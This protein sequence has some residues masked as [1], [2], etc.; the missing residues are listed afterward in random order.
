MKRGGVCWLFAAIEGC[1]RHESACSEDC[2][3]AWIPGATGS[4]VCYVEQEAAAAVASGAHPTAWGAAPVWSD[5]L[6]STLMMGWSRSYIVAGFPVQD[7]Q[8]ASAPDLA[9]PDLGTLRSCASPQCERRM[10]LSETVAGIATATTPPL[11]TEAEGALSKKL[12]RR[13]EVVESSWPIRGG[14]RNGSTIPASEQWASHGRMTDG[15]VSPKW[16][17]PRPG[18]RDGQQAET[19]AREP[20]VE[21]LQAMRWAWTT[22]P[23]HYSN[24]YSP[25][26]RNRRHWKTV[27][28]RTTR[29]G[30]RRPKKAGGEPAQSDC[31]HN[32]ASQPGLSAPQ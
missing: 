27:D 31:G 3:R 14:T 8:P 20:K 11:W 26:I 16:Q 2:D 25:N 23:A 15:F 12:R 4:L 24:S 21:G 29:D 19:D 30:R 32:S 28:V 10:A 6:R 1:L 13:P 22:T 5:C 17:T 18:G 7:L 9:A